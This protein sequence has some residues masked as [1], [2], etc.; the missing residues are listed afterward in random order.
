M[1]IEKLE[2]N[3]EQKKAYQTFT[4]DALIDIVIR[5]NEQVAE[6]QTKLLDL[7]DVIV[8]VC[9]LH[10]DAAYCKHR[11]KRR[12]TFTGKCYFKQTEL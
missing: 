12:C 4:K 11:V 6:L 10:P 5:K 3:R 8:T 9:E 7:L 1:D 2:Y